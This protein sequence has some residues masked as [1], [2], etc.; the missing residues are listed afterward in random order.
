MGAID[1]RFVQKNKLLRI[2]I[3]PRKIKAFD[4][5]T[6][7]QVHAIVKAELDIGGTKKDTWLY[8][9]RSIYGADII[10]G[11]PWMRD[12]GVVLD[13]AARRVIFKDLGIS[14]P[15]VLPGR[16]IQ[17]VGAHA[18][19]LLRKLARKE[20]EATK[21][22]RVFSI[23]LADIEKAL[24][25]KTYSDPRVKLPPQYHEFLSI[26]DRE[27]ASKLPPLRGQGVDHNI[28]LV[29]D[30]N[31]NTPT[32]PHGPL[33]SMSRDELL[34][35]RKTLLDLLD[36]GFIRVSSSPAAA[37]I[38][39]V[40][41]PGGGLRFCV[42]YRAL[43]NITKKDRY[44]LPLVNETLERI[45]KA[46]WFT[47]LDVIS[48]FHKIRMA[49]GSEWLT[50]F[51]T[52]YGL[53]EWLVTPFGLANAPSTFQKYIN[54]AIREF[55]DEFA[56]AYIDDVLVFTA[57]SLPEH[58]KHVRLILDR[59]QKAGLHLDIDKCEFEVKS[60]RYL[61]FIVEAGKGVRMDPAKVKSIVEWEAPTTVRGVRAFL[62]FANFYRRFI[63]NFSK[64]AAPLTELTRKN[65]R[66]EWTTAADD[67]FRLLKEMFISAPVLMQFDPDRETVLEVDS[68]GYVTG[69]LLSQYDDKG[70]LRPCAYFSQKN[71]PAECNYEIYD[72]ELLAIV[73]CVREWSSELRGVRHF[74]IITDHQNLTYFTTTRRLK[75]RQMRWWEELSGFNFTIQYRPGK[76]GTQPDVLS[77]REQDMPLGADARFT[78]REAQLLQ[79]EKLLGFPDPSVL[80]L[81]VFPRHLERVAIGTADDEE[82]IAEEGHPIDA[83]P[84]SDQEPS[85]MDGP[86]ENG[87][88]ELQHLWTTARHN[89]MILHEIMESIRRNDRRFPP[90]LRVPVSMSECSLDAE[91]DV[92]FRGRKW[93]PNSEP[94]RT[95]LTQEAH[96]S[97]L[98][99]HPGREGT[100]RVLARQ[101]YW[102][103]MS[104][105]NR[106]FCQNCKQCGSNEIWRDRKHGLLKPLPLPER[107]WRD[108][109]I[110]FIVDLPES[111][112]CTN[113]M[114]ITDRLTRGIILEPMAKI[115]VESTVNAFTHIF[116]R[117]HGLPYSIV[118]DRG[119]AFIGFFWKRLCQ[120]LRIQRRLSSAHHPE[121]DGATERFNA[122]IEAFLRTYISYDQ[123]NWFSLIPHCELAINS[124]AS[125]ATGLSAFFLDHG[126]DLEV[127]QLSEPVIDRSGTN[128]IAKGERI[129]KKLADAHD[130]ALVM[131]ANA[132]ERYE[133]Y[134]NVH[135][136]AAPEYR[137][138]DRVWLNYR[139]MKTDRPSKKLD[140]LHGK[141][142]VLEKVGTHAYRL[143]TP[144]GV[145]NV[146]HTWLLRPAAENP[147]PSQIV[148]PTN[149]PPVLV[150]DEEG[151]DF[152][153]EYH[154]EAIVN[155]RLRRYGRGEPRHEFLVK[156]KGYDKPT[157]EPAS[158][159]KD[160]EA[161]DQWNTSRETN[162][163]GG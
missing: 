25:P 134:A 80:Q 118:S 24:K 158:A 74:T 68:S 7:V 122:V 107:K 64:L 132:Q 27:A 148:P 89:D 128:E 98:S 60:T 44:P 29:T 90:K 34:V 108:I 163:G 102:P 87:D 35:L 146:F 17:M 6:E 16:D 14:V 10:L 129:A 31:G 43:N 138:G 100:Y 4:D 66:F 160:T 135:R 28:E 50:A 21:E 151:S 94:L 40:K 110:D 127:I 54:W 61:G 32:V 161:L 147:L 88:L 20:R 143:D 57:G 106:R 62:G 70:T 46:T 2:E 76:E 67:A 71:T 36:K 48:A 96:D 39:F 69:G 131:L 156:W 130:F 5:E 82:V 162:Q 11:T 139:H 126:Y 26:F 63:K 145:H 73:K 136:Q 114:V 154:V 99:G 79:P 120:L 155:E 13:V 41:K 140:A 47:K 141:Y 111:N 1:S 153:E 49:E 38:L 83:Q 18:F 121:T 81:A 56:S 37:P 15:T 23:T 65:Q 149:P 85:W 109:S 59:L 157:W 84:N 86:E 93:V 22:S 103:G 42:D 144:P 52:R 105:F 55:L 97:I 150:Y 30:K 58:R 101:F 125:T 104:E 45:G 72:K 78:H 77:R 92:T 116:Y 53:Y 8:E 142:T 95:R 133:R 75:E 119:S 112:K 115:D 3:S 19:N 117:R 124:R 12:M 9:V 123:S 51:R 33:Y 152:N 113:L 159:L 137:P 91:G